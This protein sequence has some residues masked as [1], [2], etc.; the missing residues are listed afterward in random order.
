[1]YIVMEYWAESIPVAYPE[2]GNGKQ[3]NRLSKEKRL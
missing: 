3:K 2:A 1:M